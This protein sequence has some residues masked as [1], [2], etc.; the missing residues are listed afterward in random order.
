MKMAQMK[1]TPT[2]AN[3]LLRI[4]RTM[5]GLAR[6]FAKMAIIKAIKR[7]NNIAS[8]KRIVLFIENPANPLYCVIRDRTSKLPMDDGKPE[9]LPAP[10][11]ASTTTPARQDIPEVEDFDFE[12]EFN[13]LLQAALDAK[14]PVKSLFTKAADKLMAAVGKVAAKPVG[15]VAPVKVKVAAAKPK[16][17]AKIAAKAVKPAA[18]AT[19]PAAKATKP[20]DKPKAAAKATKPAVKAKR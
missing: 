7:A 10:I 14:K 19:K 15:K 13:D 20:A 2:Q 8:H 9:A 11:V 5:S 4:R 16:A 6:K 1:C 17:P 3:E 18:K 12:A